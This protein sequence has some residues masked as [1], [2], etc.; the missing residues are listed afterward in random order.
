VEVERE[1]TGCPRS[2]E[3]QSFSSMLPIAYLVGVVASGE[4]EGPECRAG[5]WNRE[6]EETRER[7]QHVEILAVADPPTQ[8]RTQ[9]IEANCSASYYFYIVYGHARL[10]AGNYIHTST[11]EELKRRKCTET[12]TKSAH[13]VKETYGYRNRRGENQKQR[14]QLL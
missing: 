12:T 4:A 9:S 11:T 8:T 1:K 5:A 6:R 14:N 3:V 10:R 2:C 7:V 13:K